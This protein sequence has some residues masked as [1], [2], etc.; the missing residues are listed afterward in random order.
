MSGRAPS[1]TCW[2]PSRCG[3]SR[4]GRG[5]PRSDPGNAHA[6]DARHR[7][8]RR[9]GSVVDRRQRESRDGRAALPL[10]APA[11]PAPSLAAK[12]PRRTTTNAA[13]AATIASRR[14]VI[15]A[16][17]RN[18]IALPFLTTTGDLD[19]CVRQRT[20][21]AGA[22]T[23]CA[24]FPRRPRCVHGRSVEFLEVFR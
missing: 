8:V 7:P 14:I 13:V 20:F 21:R 22:G 10:N 16:S 18:R 11:G 23:G 6:P 1:G 19:A 17:R 15:T 4:R 2:R 12:P 9:V 3:L 24:E 5:T